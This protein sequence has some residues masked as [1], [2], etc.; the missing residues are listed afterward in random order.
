[1]VGDDG[2]HARLVL[3][4]LLD[5]GLLLPPGDQRVD[6]LCAFNIIFSQSIEHGHTHILHWVADHFPEDRWNDQRNSPNSCADAAQ[7]GHL[8][9]LRWLREHGFAWNPSTIISAS[10][11]GHDTIVQ[12]ARDN[13]CPEPEDGVPSELY[14]DW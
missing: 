13:G 8:E 12:W 1:M 7:C 11:M 2:A 14:W 4:W 10:S 9:V 6:M 5:S 3:Q